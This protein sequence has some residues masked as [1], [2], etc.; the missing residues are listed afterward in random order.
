M[1]KKEPI[2][3]LLFC[4][5]STLFL[6]GGVSADDTKKFKPQQNMTPKSDFERAMENPPKPAPYTPP[7]PHAGRVKIPGTDV[8]VSGRPAAGGGEVNVLT[9]TK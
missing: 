5:V 6:C 4:S 2:A 3:A 9:T 1:T 8:S 7:D